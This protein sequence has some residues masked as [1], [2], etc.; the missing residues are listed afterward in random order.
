MQGKLIPTGLYGSVLPR[1]PNKKTFS[2]DVKGVQYI[3]IRMVL[4]N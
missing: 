2:F 3:E 4:F 1:R